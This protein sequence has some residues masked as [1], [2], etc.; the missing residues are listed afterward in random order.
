M[1]GSLFGL[2]LEP[3]STKNNPRQTRTCSLCHYI[4]D[5]FSYGASNRSCKLLKVSLCYYMQW[6]LFMTTCRANRKKP[7]R[8]WDAHRQREKLIIPW[9]F[10]LPADNPMQSECA[11]HIG[12]AGNLFCR[13][14]EVARTDSFKRGGY[15]FCSLFE[16]ITNWL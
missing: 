15:G 1:V 9:L 12:L 2:L 10:V 3:L 4:S 16:V 13:T 14:C 6:S 8:V 5:C 11:S 7:L